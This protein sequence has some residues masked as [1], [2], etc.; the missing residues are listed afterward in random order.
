MDLIPLL[1]KVRISPNALED[2][3][4]LISLVAYNRLLNLLEERT[5]KHNI[6]LELVL[7]TR[8]ILNSIGPL[9]LI[10]KLGDTT[11]ECVENALKY[12]RYHTN[13]VNWEIIKSVEPNV[14]ELKWTPLTPVHNVRHLAENALGIACTAMRF[15]ASDE[16]KHPVR[17]TFQHRRPGDLSLLHDFFS[18]PIEFDAPANSL[19]FDQGLLELETMGADSQ[20]AEIVYSYLET[21]IEKVNSQLSLPSS[22]A[23]VIGQLLPSGRCSI[24]LVAKAVSLHPK[25]LQRELKKHGTNYSK[26][27]ERV[28]RDTAIRLLCETNISAAK[29]A[30]LC[31]YSSPTSFNLAFRVWEKTTPA[32]Y[33]RK[34]LYS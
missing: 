7:A 26:I 12:L 3:S 31:G 13:G 10:L 32:R 16:S 6:G 33:R 5:A 9:A 4:L 27:L 34:M 20:V 18:C 15:L 28:R 29:I 23:A 25:A 24:E 21:E 8:N 22:V 11:G 14:G 30:L 17:V 2:S 19:F 1:E